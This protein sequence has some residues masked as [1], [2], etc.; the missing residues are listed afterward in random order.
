MKH[1]TS[2]FRICR[3]E[4]NIDRLQMITGDPVNIMV[5]HICQRHIISL[6]KRQSWIVIFEIQCFTHPL[7]HLINKTENAL[8]SAGPV[9]IHQTL[10]KG[11]TQILLIF[12]F[13]LKFPLLAVRL[14]NQNEKILIID[15][16][17]VIKNILDFLTVYRKKPVPR[18]DAHLPC[19]TSL[20]YSRNQMFMSFPLFF[21]ISSP[22]PLHFPAFFHNT[23]FL[24]KMQFFLFLSCHTYKKML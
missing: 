10:L 13:Y 11:Q 1:F 24:P 23:K 20:F 4:G 19:N 5:A 7:W 9:L 22:F 16:V 12:F 2:K 17:M 14:L 6:Q 15:I 18:F 21:H 3:M 8:V